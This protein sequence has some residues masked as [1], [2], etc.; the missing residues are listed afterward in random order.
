[1]LRQPSYGIIGVDG[2]ALPQDGVIE[3]YLG[4]VQS[5][6]AAVAGGQEKAGGWD[7][8]ADEGEILTAA[9]PLPDGEDALAKQ[10]C[11]ILRHT[12]GQVLVHQHTGAGIIKFCLNRA[13][14]S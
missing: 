11:C 13:A 3:S 4:V 2:T 6:A 9:A 14:Q 8:V 5:I 7:L 1:M 10:L 12:G